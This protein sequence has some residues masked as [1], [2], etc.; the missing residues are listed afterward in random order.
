M[1][2]TH[3]IKLSSTPDYISLYRGLR[4]LV[5]RYL[6]DGIRSGSTDVYALKDPIY[7]LI[8]WSNDQAKTQTK[9][10]R[11]KQGYR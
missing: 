5:A 8:A 4:E 3:P 10:V 1:T 11:K 7:Q 2:T 6:K 9:I